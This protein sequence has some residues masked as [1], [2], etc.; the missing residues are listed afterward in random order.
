M[1]KTKDQVIKN[2]NKGEYLIIG[3]D[4]FWY[5]SGLKTIKDAEKEI[6]YI[7]RDISKYGEPNTGNSRTKVPSEFHIYK[8]ILIKS[9]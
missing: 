8:A 1:S 2:L 4:D 3:S 6:K 7:K 5:G 9:I